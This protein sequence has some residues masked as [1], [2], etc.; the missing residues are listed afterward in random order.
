MLSPYQRYTVRGEEEEREHAA[1]PG[2]PLPLGSPAQ[3]GDSQAGSPGLADFHRA[4]SLGCFL[5]DVAKSA[6]PSSASSVE[7]TACG[8][9]FP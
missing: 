2:R 4:K 5:S 6:S 9:S 7:F 1:L 8:A 3:A